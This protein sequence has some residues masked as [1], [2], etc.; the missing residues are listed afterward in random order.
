MKAEKILIECRALFVNDVEE[1]YWGDYVFDLLDITAYNESSK[2]FTTIA[3]ST[4][5]PNEDHRITIGHK[6]YEF[7]TLTK[8]FI[9]ELNWRIVTS[10]EIVKIINPTEQ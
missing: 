9:K 5:T 8:S 10:E 3:L 7:H 1:E 6:F 2:G 4:V